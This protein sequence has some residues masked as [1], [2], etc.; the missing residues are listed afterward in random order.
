M[1]DSLL[2]KDMLVSKVAIVG[3]S[4]SWKRAPFDESDWEIWGLNEGYKFMP[5]WDRWFELHQRQVNLNDEGPAHIWKLAALTCPIYMQRH[6]PDIPTSV[7]F[8]L[9]EILK[10]FPRKYFTS[11]FSYMMAWAI[12]EKFEEIGI[13]GV[14]TADEEL[15]SQRPSLEYFIGIAEGKGIKVTIPGESSLCR[16][17]FL[18]GYQERESDEFFGKLANQTSDYRQK[19][20]RCRDMR[21][22]Y[23][24]REAH[25]AGAVEAIEALRND[26]RLPFSLE[27]DYLEET[28]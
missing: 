2:S 12:L 4:A 16:A 23:E 21:K 24:L 14:D 15:G 25:Y 3:F 5:R 27:P 7:A 9:E 20:D 8:P 11:S 18:Y 26:W 19:L 13:Y 6:F 22:H 17:P 10:T 1:R 28:I